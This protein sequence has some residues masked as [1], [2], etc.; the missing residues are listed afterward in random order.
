[1]KGKSHVKERKTF[2]LALETKKKFVSSKRHWKIILKLFDGVEKALRVVADYSNPSFVLSGFSLRSKLKSE[3]TKWIDR[4]LRKALFKLNENC[5]SYRNVTTNSC[6]VTNESL[7]HMENNFLPSLVVEKSSILTMQ[8]QN[9]LRKKRQ[10]V[11]ENICCV[12]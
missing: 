2:Q 7:V 6:F 4:A 12:R 10:I 5:S 3:L 11:C 1:M 8:N 9:R